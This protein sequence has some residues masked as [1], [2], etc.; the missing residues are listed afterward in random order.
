M[1]G[2]VDIKILTSVLEEEFS[3]SDILSIRSLSEPQTSEDCANLTFALNEYGGTHFLINTRT[4]ALVLK[5]FNLA[6][7]RSQSIIEAQLMNWLKNAEFSIIPTVFRTKTGAPLTKIV[8]RDCLL[9]SYIPCQSN[10]LW[11]QPTWTESACTGAGEVLARLHQHLST[12]TE[13]Q[14]ADWQLSAKLPPS[15]L[16]NNSE[17]GVSSVRPYLASWLARSFQLAGENV[18]DLGEKQATEVLSYK[19][20]LSNLLEEAEKTI[21]SARIQ[22]NQSIVHGDFHAANLLWND[23]RI[24]AII[25]FEHAHFEHPLYDLAYAVCMFSLNW[26]NQPEQGSFSITYAKALIASYLS[27]SP[28]HIETDFRTLFPS[29]LKLTTTLI[30]CWL[31]NDCLRSKRF[32]LQLHAFLSY[33]SELENIASILVSDS[34]DQTRSAVV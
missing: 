9:Q 15:A 4:V 29:Y 32:H 30:F 22:S 7:P 24:K 28:L 34:T 18:N 2:T 33:V 26:L 6:H 31:L 14:I 10:Y 16:A 13:K 23:N 21:S 17:L 12:L 5:V 25:D 11:Y 3:L 1:T 20:I 27:V 8:G 19:T